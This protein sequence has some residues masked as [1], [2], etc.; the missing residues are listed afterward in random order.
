MPVQLAGEKNL[1]GATPVAIKE[2]NI[3]VVD[4]MAIIQNV[5]RA[6]CSY[7]NRLNMEIFGRTITPH[8]LS[9]P[10]MLVQFAGVSNL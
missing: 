2:S 8:T 7:S 6:F 4:Y 1:R 10:G 9:S 3:F 5:L